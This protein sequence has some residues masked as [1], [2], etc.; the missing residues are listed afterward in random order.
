MTTP[1][2]IPPVSLADIAALLDAK[3]GD[4]LSQQSKDAAERETKH[5]EEAAKRAEAAA[6]R[7][8]MR[9]EAAAERETM[10][11]EAAAEREVKRAEEAAKRD[12]ALRAAISDLRE[13][14]AENK[15]EAAKRETRLMRWSVTAFAASAVALGLWIE[16]RDKPVAPPITVTTPPPVVY[17]A[18]LAAAPPVAGDGDGAIQR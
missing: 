5:A 12:A 2:N 3:V 18:P 17:A 16:L 13:D 7:E 6:E 1:A 9:A 10:R 8:T 14:M 4:I 11:A 15:A